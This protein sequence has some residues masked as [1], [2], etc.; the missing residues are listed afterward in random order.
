[1]TQTMKLAMPALLRRFADDEAGATSVE[2]CMIASCIFLAIVTVIGLVG[3]NVQKPFQT[4][5]QGLQ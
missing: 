2:Y 4:A 5:N 3:V 1:V